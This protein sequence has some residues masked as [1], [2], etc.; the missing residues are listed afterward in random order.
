MPR[1]SSSVIDPIQEAAKTQPARTLYF[2]QEPLQSWVHGLLTTKRDLGRHYGWGTM[3]IHL[4]RACEAALEPGAVVRIGSKER[5]L[6]Q[7]EC[8]SVQRFLAQNHKT[9]S[10]RVAVAREFPNQ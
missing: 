7:D 5:A 10:F 1:S 3:Q 4:V 6:T 8:A 9:D 2:D